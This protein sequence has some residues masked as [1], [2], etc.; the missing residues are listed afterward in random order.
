MPLKRV[1]YFDHQFL[2]VHDFQAEQDYHISMRHRHNRLLHGR[3]VVEGLEVRQKS[4]REITIEPGMAIDGSGKEIVVEGAIT[5]QM[6]SVERNAHVYIVIRHKDRRDDADRYSSGGIED[7]TR[8]TESFE[9]E[10]RQD[11]SK[12]GTV[13]TLARVHLDQNGNILRIESNVRELVSSRGSAVGW[14]RMAFKPARLE[15]LRLGSELQKPTAKEWDPSI[16]FIIDVGSA[17][18]DKE[19]ARGTMDIPVPPGANR[20]THLRICGTTQQ[21]VE[22]EWVR[23]GWNSE[24]H[25]GEHKVLAKRTLDRSGEHEHF[26]ENVALED[27]AQRFSDS[28][29]LSISVIA[30]G[31]ATIWLVAARFE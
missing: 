5:C 26:D 9:I 7:H 3:G 17:Y 14:V 29:T 19:G 8:L 28:Q 13:V 30:Y 10:E 12:D 4:Q 6:V 15:L 27:D 22:V 11:L 31:K 2:K 20:I 21:K 23:A 1:H 16:E 25:Q 24:S 18:C